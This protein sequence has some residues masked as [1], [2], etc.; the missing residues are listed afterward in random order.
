MG[1]E[2]HRSFD[3]RTKFDNEIPDIVLNRGI[4]LIFSFKTKTYGDRQELMRES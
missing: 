1:Y 4:N 3:A 2:N